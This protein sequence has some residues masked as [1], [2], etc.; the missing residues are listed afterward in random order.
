[1]LKGMKIFISSL[2][3]LFCVFTVNADMGRVTTS[4]AVVSEDAQQAII[5]HNLEEEILILGTD[6]KADKKTTILRFI[7]FP[8]EPTVSLVEGKP[9]DRVSELM[10]EHNMVFLNFSKS[11]SSSSDPVEVTFSAK[12][13]AHDIT[14]I[15]INEIAEFKDWVA[16]FLKGKG[17]APEGDNQQVMNVASD[18]VKREI[19]YFV[20]DL[21]EITPEAQF[22]EPIAY[23]FKSREFYYPLK[24]S[25]TFGG[26]GGIDLIIVAPGTLCD[27]GPFSQALYMEKPKDIYQ[28]SPP[29][30]STL[31]NKRPFSYPVRASTTAELSREEIKAIYAPAKSFFKKN[32]PV[33]MQLIRYHGEYDFDDDI[34]IDISKAPKLGMEY[35]E[36]PGDESS[37]VQFMKTR[38]KSRIAADP[39]YELKKACLEATLVAIQL[40]IFRFE[41]KYAAAIEGLGNPEN[42]PVINKRISEL[43]VE[44]GKYKK[45][46]PADYKLPE[47]KK[48]KI[49]TTQQ[50]QEDSI[51]ELK[52][53]SR[54][55]PFYH[56]AGILGNDY[57]SVKSDKTYRM[58]IYP[59][60]HRDYPFPSDY[61]YI[62]DFHVKRN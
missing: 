5:F 36:Y 24:T 41:D 48:V 51:L 54:S 29:C 45:M 43:N 55:G 47:M 52:N 6:L 39:E 28:S 57:E 56:I 42:A 61:V 15:C 33:V 34:L 18:Y 59:V 3:L 17:L 10:K 26:S 53:M 9:F 44:Y 58:T 13:G 16:E 40:E 1:M 27:T 19:N 12:I 37:F 38:E 2:L 30:L 23:R 62:A 4:D 22:V 49:K 32:E 21:V 7:P 11:G 25:N 14:V 60:Y 35:I 50:Y 20:F 31:S 8:S 46:H